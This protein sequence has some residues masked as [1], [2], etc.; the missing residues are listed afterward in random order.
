MP[1]EFLYDEC[2]RLG[3]KLPSFGKYGVAVV[4][5][6]RNEKVREECKETL[7]R[8]LEELSMK[9]LGYRALPTVNEDLGSMAL[10]GAPVMEQL[11]IQSPEIGR[12]ACWVRVC[13][14]VEI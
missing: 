4:F 3:F 14:Y 11:F 7:E 1:H 12:A 2:L 6:P 5:F 10:A 13:M 9:Q 8:K